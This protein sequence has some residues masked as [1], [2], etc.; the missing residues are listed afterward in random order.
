LACHIEFTTPQGAKE[1]GAMALFEEKY[2]DEV[3]VLSMGEFSVELCGGTHVSRT[4][5][6]GAF[7][8]IQETGIAAGVRRIE[9]I[10]GEKVLDY[11]DQQESELRKVAELLKAPREDV[12][13]RLQQVLTQNRAQEKTITQYKLQ[14]LQTQ[15]EE[16]MNRAASVQGISVLV[17]KIADAD[18]EGLR[19]LVELYKQK[20][21]QGIVL[22]STVLD[23]KVQLVAGVSKQTTSQIKAGDLVGFVAQQLGGKGGGRPDLAQGGGERVEQLDAVL[24][25]VVPWV[26]QKLAT[27]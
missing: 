22:L 8:I 4:G 25:Q 19:H 20:S 26:E 15:F 6:I 21:P 5:D 12:T 1:K 18:V 2:G 14:L 23:N 17:E 11:L 3:R 16:L 24:A 10:T 27:V 13:T 9:A 7:R